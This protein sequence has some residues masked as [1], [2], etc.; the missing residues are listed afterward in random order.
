MVDVAGQG[1][2]KGHIRVTPPKR[3]RDLPVVLFSL[4][5][6]SFFTYLALRRANY[7]FV[8]YAAVV[9]V[10]ALWIIVKQPVVQFEPLILWGLSAWG[11]LHMAGGNLSVGDDVLYNVQLVPRY[12]RFD[13]FVHALGFGTATLVCHNILRPHLR[14]KSS[15]QSHGRNQRRRLREYD[16]GPGIQPRRG[17][18]GDRLDHEK[19]S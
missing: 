19:D 3:R 14:E 1:P 5:Y 18:N 17:R 7:E 9:I 8:L 10:L 13:Q 4:V 2:L 6:I 11:L 16:V 12:L 15:R